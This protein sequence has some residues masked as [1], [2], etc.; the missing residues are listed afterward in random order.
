MTSN[1]EN[2]WA[3]AE[4]TERGS[5]PALLKVG[6]AIVNRGV[7]RASELRLIAGW[8][9]TIS[10][11]RPSTRRLRPG[12]RGSQLLLRVPSTIPLAPAWSTGRRI[13]IGMCWTE[14][15]CGTA[16]S[17]PSEARFPRAIRMIVGLAGAD[18]PERYRGSF[19]DQ[20]PSDQ[21]MPGRP[22]SAPGTLDPLIGIRRGGAPGAARPPL[23]TTWPS[24][25][26]SFEARRSE[27]AGSCLC[28]CEGRHACALMV[29]GAV[30]RR[31]TRRRIQGQYSLASASVSSR[32][33]RKSSPK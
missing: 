27:E 26:Q 12:R 33:V 22:A 15:A 14:T 8:R 24:S 4:P 18:R 25:S 21:G 13:Q 11:M 7:T 17:R 31:R 2:V 10:A 20:S 19:D 5:H 30:P 29:T 3:R 28:R 23:V 9:A 6:I 32:R 1:D 16:R